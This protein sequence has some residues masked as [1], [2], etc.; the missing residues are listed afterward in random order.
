MGEG[1]AAAASCGVL[2]DLWLWTCAAAQ[3]PGSCLRPVT[4]RHGRGLCAA[5]EQCLAAAAPTLFVCL[6]HAQIGGI[7]PFMDTTY[8]RDMVRHQELAPLAAGGSRPWVYAHPVLRSCGWA[9]LIVPLARVCVH[10]LPC[11]SCTRLSV[12]PPRAAHIPHVDLPADTTAC[13]PPP[14][15]PRCLWTSSPASAAGTATTCAPPLT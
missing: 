14:A 10:T 8:E 13:P 3:E 2:K 1:P 4:Q 9:Y 7:N 12:P 6:A 11:P 15:C 5:C